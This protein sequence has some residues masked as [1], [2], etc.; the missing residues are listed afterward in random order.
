M[1]LL[2]EEGVE[3]VEVELFKPCEEQDPKVSH[4]TFDKDRWVFLHK[5]IDCLL[6]DRWWTEQER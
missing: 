4:T 3:C 6:H 5:V 1:Y 2:H